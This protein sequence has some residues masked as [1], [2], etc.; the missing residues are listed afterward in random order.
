MP[1]IVFWTNLIAILFLRF[2]SLMILM[3]ISESEFGLGL[4]GETEIWDNSG[5]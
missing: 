5:L 1:K 3:R 4:Q 2:K